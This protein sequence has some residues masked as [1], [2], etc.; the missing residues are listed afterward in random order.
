M[1]SDPA[2]DSAAFENEQ[3][4]HKGIRLPEFFI[5]KY[6]ATND[7]YAAFIKAT[8]RRAPGHWQDGRVPQ[9]KGD[10][11]VVDVSW[12]DAVAFTSWLSMET[13]SNFRLPTEA[14]WEKACP[15]KHRTY[16]PL[17]LHVRC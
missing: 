9:S 16:L 5:G 11:P 10:H 1:G 12:D 4:Q 7:Q 15:G 8:G 3:P 17:G 13:G 14:E 2:R 6:E